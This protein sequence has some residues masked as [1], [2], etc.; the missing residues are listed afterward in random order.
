MKYHV[1]L[2]RPADSEFVSQ[3]GCQILA[4]FPDSLIVSCSEEQAAQLR[5]AGLELNE[6]VTPSVRLLGLRF[7]VAAAMATAYG[8]EIRFACLSPAHQITR[9]RHSLSDVQTTEY[10]GTPSRHEES[11]GHASREQ[12][13]II[14]RVRL[15]AASRTR[16]K[17]QPGNSNSVFRPAV[18]DAAPGLNW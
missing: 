2:S 17:L 13:R 10:D 1:T 4:E 14:A 7:G 6:M 15:H 12:L 9:C 8:P 5:A 18:P 3:S 11:T 16:L